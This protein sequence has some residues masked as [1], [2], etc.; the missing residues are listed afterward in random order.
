M[1]TGVGILLKKFAPRIFE[2]LVK[3]CEIRQIRKDMIIGDKVCEKKEGTQY[4]VLNGHIGEAIRVMRALEK[5]REFYSKENEKPQFPGGFPSCDKVID[6]IIVITTERKAAITRLWNTADDVIILSDKEVLSIIRYTQYPFVHHENVLL[7]FR[8]TN[9]N[10]EYY[11][12]LHGVSSWSI[13]WALQIPPCEEK[14]ISCEYSKWTIEQGEKMVNKYGVIKNKAIVLIPSANTL[15]NFPTKF[16]EKL[17]THLLEKG[18]KVFINYSAENDQKIVGCDAISIDFPM[19]VF[20]YFCEYAGKVISNQSGLGDLIVWSGRNIQTDMLIYDEE[21]NSTV[22][23]YT[24]KYLDGGLKFRQYDEYTKYH[25]IDD[26]DIEGD[27]IYEN[28]A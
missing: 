21:N 22:C 4:I 8:W 26:A 3:H 28:L 11:Y 14:M 16:W 18:L 10:E 24:H 23:D 9:M 19:D 6:R 7:P 13:G 12:Q 2:K 17:I 25:L 1:G 5:F 15:P 27:S 20:L